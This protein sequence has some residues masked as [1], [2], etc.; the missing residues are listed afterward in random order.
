MEVLLAMELALILG[1]ALRF[2]IGN[3][4]RELKREPLWVRQCELERD[5]FSSTYSQR[6]LGAPL[7]RRTAVNRPRPAWN[8]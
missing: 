5:E 2:S 6:P 1:L 7:R 4:E 8:S 3:I